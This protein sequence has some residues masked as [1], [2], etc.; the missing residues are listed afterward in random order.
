MND[1]APAAFAEWL[2]SPALSDDER[3]E[4]EEIIDDE[5]EIET[6]FGVLPEFGTAGLRGVMGVGLSLLNIHVIKWV[7]QAFAD[8]LNETREDGKTI[9]FAVCH[10]CRHNSRQFAEAAASVLAANGIHVLLF[11]GMRPTPE[12]SFAVRRYGCDAGINITASHNTRE[13]NGYKAYGSNGAQLNNEDA[14]KVAARMNEIDVF[15]APKTI[16]LG[17]AQRQGLLTPLGHDTDEEFLQKCMSI[18]HVDGKTKEA[19][20][21]LR[22]VYT[23]FHGAGRDL[24]PEALRRLGFANVVCVAEQMIPDGDFP[25]VKSPNPE[26]AES[27]ALAEKYAFDAD[28]DLIIG[29]DP[30]SDRIAIVI[31]RNGGYTHLNGNSIGAVLLD[32]YLKTLSQRKELPRNAAV[33]KTIVTTDLAVKIAENYGAKC[34]NTFTGFKF[35]ADRRDEL[36][37]SGEGTVVY[38]FEEANGIMLGDFTRDKDAVSASVLAAECAAYYLSQ[39]TTILDALDA[40]YAKYGAHYESTVSLVMPGLD[41]VM[42]M[43]QLMHIL[44][45]EPPAEIASHKVI[46]RS[47]YKKG[48]SVDENGAESKMD[49]R[50]MDVLQFE[51]DDGAKLLVRPSG[52]EP[53]I[54]V[55]VLVSAGDTESARSKAQGYIDWAQ[56][57]PAREL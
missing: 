23:P 22:I 15:S 36:E 16:P 19:A 40:V 42:K 29:T 33:I 9:K 1:F 30:D 24:I 52:T 55:Y 5:R 28:A 18:A 31:K 27:F 39:G 25:T 20:G 35:I 7:T 14:A 56:S 21:K 49:L 44:R 46:K 13:Y 53:K 37:D 17:D 2:N 6:R 11:D 10:D 50:G 47:D 57:L 3:R 41:G 32:Y 45:V 8:V 38:S 12:L 34:Y 26:Y 48:V 51:L 43:R 4:L 54:K